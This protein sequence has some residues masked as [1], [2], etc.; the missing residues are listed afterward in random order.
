MEFVGPER[1]YGDQGHKA[2]WGKTCP[3]A[4]NL[5]IKVLLIDTHVGYST[6][7]LNIDFLMARSDFWG[8]QIILKE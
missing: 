2:S 4:A 6:T 3:S 7:K 5:P 8:I 1:S